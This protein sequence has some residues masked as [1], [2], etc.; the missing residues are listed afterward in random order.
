MVARA[1]TVCSTPGCPEAVT[2]KG[3]CP[4]H[5]PEPWQGSDRASRLPKNWATI[6]NRIFRRDHY[7]CRLRFPGCTRVATEV[8]HIIRG[9]DHRPQ[10]L[11]SLCSNCH[12]VKTQLEANASRAKQ[13]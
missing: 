12:T 10:N 7:L 11:Q 5:Q 8:D 3:K 2:S 1:G 9:D 13:P 6:R 4:E